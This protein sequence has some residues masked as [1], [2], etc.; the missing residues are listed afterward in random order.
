M[1]TL[2]LQLKECDRRTVELRYQSGSGYTS[3]ILNLAEIQELLEAE[4]VNYTE[5]NPRLVEFGQ[6]LF[7]WLDGSGRWLSRLIDGQSDRLLVLAI[8]C[9]QGL[10]VLPWETLH[11]GRQFLID[12]VNP[13][14]VPVRWLP[15]K[16]NLPT[17]ALPERPLQVLFMATAPEEVE[18]VLAFEVEESLILQATAGMGLDLRVEESGCLTE[19]KALWGRLGGN[20][21][22]FH[23]SGH[24]GITSGEKVE[25]VFITESETGECVYATAQDLAQVFQPRFPALIFLSGCRTGQGMANQAETAVSS[26]AE[27]LIQQGAIA[28]LGWGLPV[29]DRTA[30]FAAMALYQGLAE[31]RTLPEALALTYTALRQQKVTD[32]HLL[33]LY[34]QGNGIGALVAPPGDFIYERSQ[35]QQL[36]LDPLTQQVRVAAPDEFVG[37]RRI[38]QAGLRQLRK[39]RGLLLYGLGG[40]GKSTIAARLLERLRGYERLVIHRGLDEDKLISLLSQYCQ[41]ET[42]QGILS[43]KLPLRQR[44][45]KFLKSGLNQPKEQLIFVLDDFE[46]NLQARGESWILSTEAAPIFEALLEAIAQSPLAHRFL[47]TCRYQ[48]EL[49]PRL[50]RYFLAK[51]VQ[52]LRGADL[53]KKCQRL[54]SFST[55]S[56]VE[57][58]LRDQAQ[59]IADGNPRLLEWLDLLLQQS[60]LDMTSIL[61]EMRGKEQEFLEDILAEQLLAQQSAAFRQ[62]LALGLIFR[63]PVPQAALAAVWEGAESPRLRLPPFQRGARGDHEDLGGNGDEQ[64]KLEVIEETG[65]PRLQFPTLERG[66][67]EL[68][69]CLERGRA[70]GLIEVF[71]RP[72]TLPTYRVPR[73][74]SGLVVLPGDGEVLA[75]VGAE[76]L[77]RL[78]WE[79]D[80]EINEEQALEIHRLALAGKA[81]E[82][83]VK[84]ANRLTAQWNNKSRFWEV[85][86]VCR[87]TLAI[88]NDYRI[89]HNLALAQQELGEIEAATFYYQQALE[90]CPVED[91][92]ENSA[93]IHNLATLY[94]FQGEID[95]AIA[96]Y[97]Q[98]IEIEEKIG[99]VQG[100]AA[101]LHEIARIYANQGEIDQ[102]I[103]L[104]QQSLEITEKIGD[105]KT[106]ASTLHQLAGIYANQG[107]I[108]QAIALFQQSLE[109]TEKIGNVQGQAATLHQLA[110]IYANQGEIDQAIALFQQSLELNEKIGDVQGKAATLHE[111]ARIYANQG[112]IDQAI[113]LYQQ[114]IEIEEKI[115]NVQGK[116][117][118]L[119]QLAIIYANQGEVDQAIA[120]YQQSLEIKEKIGDVQGKAATLHQLAILYA[121][122]G[123]I[124]QAIALYQQSIE[125]TEKIGDVKTKAATLHQLAG[126]YANRG[127]IDQAIALYQ[128]SIEF[129]EKIGNVQG[130]AIT[131]AMMGQMVIVYQQDYQQGLAYLEQSLAILQRLRSPDAATVQRIIAQ[132]RG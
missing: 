1:K 132:I 121:N 104:Y 57:A 111:I 32:W 97:Q 130:K 49:E 75:K 87:E 101:T 40:V 81:G 11:D 18:P 69:C 21:D 99:D 110:G 13:K 53:T 77:H 71:E 78:W 8:D 16:E 5:Q 59:A 102:A 2:H 124:D 100:K 35:P 86:K 96:L 14:I 56:T 44:L 24:A 37:R 114:S 129:E 17:E 115:G 92:K 118:T 93:I 29:F 128:Q 55:D 7:N 61:A 68:E 33:R 123:E 3:Q 58:D 108:D 105:V 83:A 79:S 43:E 85:V 89:F 39:N 30:I 47:I 6:R 25:P 62:L 82:I 70:L 80:F 122:Q 125:I 88:I 31:G 38:L 60:D 4:K 76:V 116:A 91:E 107:E 120:L 103:A 72:N 15:K 42:G 46:A 50:Q 73:L 67:D 63:V 41:T 117:T 94:M 74:L 54:L 112:E 48:F 109:L 28:V 45:S 90:T 119:H 65:S 66:A 20:F 22:V 131:L 126:L 106:K 12:G 64:R 98:S 113:A 51:Q 23:L 27:Q 26:M 84:I 34:V 52:A 9:S 10:A 95:Q 127:E 36:F 19:L